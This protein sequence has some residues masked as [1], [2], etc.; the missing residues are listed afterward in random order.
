[1]L[2]LL[3]GELIVQA[4][5]ARVISMLSLKLGRSTDWLLHGVLTVK[6]TFWAILYRLRA[7]TTPHRRVQS[8]RNLLMIQIHIKTSE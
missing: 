1:M 4:M 6:L 2:E 7:G 3:S 5:L 8:L